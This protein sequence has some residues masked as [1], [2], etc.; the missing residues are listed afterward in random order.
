MFFKYPFISLRGLCQMK[1]NKTIHLHVCLNQL[2]S[3][4]KKKLK[5]PDDINFTFIQRHGELQPTE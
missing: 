3:S 5:K 1:S 4:A 2:Q